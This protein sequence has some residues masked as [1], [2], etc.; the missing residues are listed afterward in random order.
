MFQKQ[1]TQIKHKIFILKNVFPGGL[2]IGNLILRIVWLPLMDIGTC[3]AHVC[4]KYGIQYIHSY[5][6]DMDFY[7]IYL[8]QM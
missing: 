7:T 5:T 6:L 8:F 4:C 3:G 2:G 1:V